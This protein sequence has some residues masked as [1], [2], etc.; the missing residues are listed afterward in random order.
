MDNKSEIFITQIGYSAAETFAARVYGRF[1]PT[2]LNDLCK[3][4]EIYFIPVGN[5][6]FCKK[7][8]EMQGIQLPNFA[9]YPT[10]LKR[11]MERNI[12]ITNIGI[13]KGISK[14]I[15]VKP[16]TTKLFTGFIWPKDC[17]DKTAL[18]NL[19]DTTILYCSDVVSF[20]SEWRYYIIHGVI[21]GKGRYDDGED[22]AQEPDINVVQNAVSDF[23]NNQSPAGYSLDFGVLD[24]GKTVLIEANDGWALGLYT[25]GTC[26]ARDYLRLLSVRWEEL[27]KLK[28]ENS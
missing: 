6:A 11:Y 19:P 20:V 13:I 10:I 26:S 17:E 24:S 12:Y 25:R 9:T 18:L 2:T 15:F 14:D 4:K 8:M 22:G 7:A 16:I 27:S 5:V 23:Q 21:V 3:I 28:N 1:K